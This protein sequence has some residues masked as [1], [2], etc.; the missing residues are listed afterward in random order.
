[1]VLFEKARGLT[2]NPLQDLTNILST[3]PKTGV[4]S[5]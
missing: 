3:P 4:K 5:H 2:L 1:M